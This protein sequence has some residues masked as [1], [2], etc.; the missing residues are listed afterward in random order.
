MKLVSW[1]VG[2]FAGWLVG[3]LEHGSGISGSLTMRLI[4]LLIE[5]L[6]AYQRRTLVHE[7]G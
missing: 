4:S 1:L 5:G 6:L 7:I 3:W 2:W